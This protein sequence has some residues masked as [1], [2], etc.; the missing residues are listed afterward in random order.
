MIIM[1]TLIDY[2]HV[3]NHYVMLNNSDTM[4]EVVQILKMTAKL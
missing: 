1:T 4:I 2:L 3:F